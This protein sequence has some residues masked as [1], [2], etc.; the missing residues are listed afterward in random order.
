MCAPSTQMVTVILVVGPSCL[1]N[2]DL[3]TLFCSAMFAHWDTRLNSV[4]SS[5]RHC[6]PFFSHWYLEPNSQVLGLVTCTASQLYQF[7]GLLFLFLLTHILRKKGIKGTSEDGHVK[8]HPY[9]GRIQWNQSQS[10][11]P[12]GHK[13]PALAADRVEEKP[14]ETEELAA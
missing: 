13:V 1:H 14:M 2:S 7:M 9:F 11:V 6:M 4:T 12:R 10:H 5:F 8:E 3:W